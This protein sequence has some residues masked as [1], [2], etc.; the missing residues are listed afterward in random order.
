[1]HPFG[2]FFRFF[3]DRFLKFFRNLC[4][5]RNQNKS[6]PSIVTRLSPL[7]LDWTKTTAQNMDQTW[8]RQSLRIPYSLKPFLKDAPNR[9]EA[10]I[11]ALKAYY[12]VNGGGGQEYLFQ[13]IAAIEKHLGIEPPP[14]PEPPPIE[15]PPAK[16]KKKRK[17]KKSPP[18]EVDT[19]A[20]DEMSPPPPEVEENPPSDEMSPAPAEVDT[21]GEEPGSEEISP[22]AE[23]DT[24]ASDEMSPAPPEVDTRDAAIVAKNLTNIRDVLNKA[25]HLAAIEPPPAEV[26][27]D[28]PASDEVSPP[29]ERIEWDKFLEDFPDKT[30]ANLEELTTIAC[31]KY[32]D[33]KPLSLRESLR[34]KLKKL[35]RRK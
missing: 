16:P 4:P 8:A 29:A 30:I 24:P 19:P 7:G 9:S 23:V 18:P 25:N 21:T 31:Q 14:A 2:S 28:T 17:A 10:I 22:P 3:L 32:P 13:R 1:M 5:R 12:G 20:S 6:V 27:P 11:D 26:E 33:R 15:V 34:T 35:A